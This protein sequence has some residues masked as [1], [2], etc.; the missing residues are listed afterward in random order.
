MW[1]FQHASSRVAGE[2]SNQQV[3]Q[4]GDG[5]PQPIGLGS[6]TMLNYQLFQKLK[7]IGRSKFNHLTI[8]LTISVFRSS[9]SP[10]NETLVVFFYLNFVNVEPY[11]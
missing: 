1:D 5:G 3:Q 6:D 9:S 4:M 2:H 7:L 8:T 10:E 11:S